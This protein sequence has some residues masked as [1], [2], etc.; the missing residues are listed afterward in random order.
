MLFFELVVMTSGGDPWWNYPGF[1]LWKFVNLAVFVCI[2]VYIHRRLGRPIR[3]A[4]RARGERIKLELRDALLERD[5]AL[6]KLEEVEA[7][8]SR[9]DEEVALAREHARL[10]ADAES[11]RIRSSTE[12]ETAKLREQG[13]REIETA[14]KIAKQELRRFAAEQSIKFAEESVR[15]ELTPEDDSR[16]I[17]TRVDQIGRGIH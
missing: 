2:A 3:Q 1:E 5:R 6:R 14:A 11:E 8:L 7:R 4:L 10:E 13:Q 12:A 9:L 17:D 15:R 16:L